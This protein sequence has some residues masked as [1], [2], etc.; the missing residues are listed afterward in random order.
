MAIWDILLPFGT[1]C[2][3]LVHFFC[4]GIMQRKKSGN[5]ECDGEKEN[6]GGDR[7][8]AGKK[9]N[10]GGDRKKSGKKENK[11][12]K[13]QFLLISWPSSF[14]GCSKPCYPSESLYYRFLQKKWRAGE[15]N[16]NLGALQGCQ[17]VCCQTENPNLGNFWRVLQWKMFV[18]FVDTWS[19]LQFF[20]IFY[21]YLVY[22][23]RVNLVYSSRFG[24]LY[25]RKIWQPWGIV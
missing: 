8:I 1:I 10:K 6:K 2:V 14:K 18:Y 24:I 23:V 11:R 21:G 25:Q 22:L 7:K 4:F 5:P 9:Q 15:K 19:I 12:R 13:V 20:V 16:T 3:H 17:M